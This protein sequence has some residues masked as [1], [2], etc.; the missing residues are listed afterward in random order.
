MLIQIQPNKTGHETAQPI[1]S[2]PSNYHLFDTQLGSH[3]YIANGSR[4]YS[5]DPELAAVLEGTDDGDS[6]LGQWEIAGQPYISD[7]PVKS[8]PVRS[9]SL[10]VAQKCNL[11]CV[12]CYAQEGTFGGSP[13]D[14]EEEVARRSVDLLLSEAAPGERVF[15]TFL[16][17][18]PLTNRPLVRSITQHAALMAEER[19]VSIGFSLTSN[20]T[21]ITVEDG[22]FFERFGFSV[23]ISLDGKGEVHDRLRSF[24]GGQASY[25]H[26]LSRVKPLLAMQKRMQVSARVTV[27]PSNLDLRETLD[28]F[29]DMGFHSVGFSPML[30]APTG[31]GEMGAT[32]LAEMLDQMIDCGREFERRLS[33]GDRYPFLNMVNAMREIHKGTHRPYPCGAGAGYFGVSAEGGLYACHRFTEEESAG[34]GDVTTGVNRERQNRWLEQRHVHHQEPC[35]S[36]WARYLC[37]GGCHHEVIHRGRPACDFIRGWLNYCLG[38]YIRTSEYRPDFFSADLSS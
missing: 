12:Y 19:C 30:S 24:K 18:E 1:V 25:E 26:I 23:T 3:V 32:E 38:A 2:K 33:V 37:G 8:P 17:G 4:I 15:L 36:C 29:I 13:R 35:R 31:K 5:L 28:E 27:T 22:A 9:L 21:L 10:A 7:E 11:G 14:M 20:G 16:G 6:I 34:M